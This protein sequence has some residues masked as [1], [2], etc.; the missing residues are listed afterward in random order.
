MHFCYVDFETRSKLDLRKVGARN[1]AV[2]ES[3]EVISIAYALDDAPVVHA[4]WIKKWPQNRTYVAHNAEFEEAIFKR[5]WNFAP[6]FLDTMAL[7]AQMSLPLSLKELAAFFGYAK[8]DTRAVAKLSKP[9]RKSKANPDGELFWERDDV[10]DDYQE[11]DEYNKTD[12][13]VMRACLKKMLPLTEK[14]R[15]I[16]Q[17]TATMNERGVRV[18]TPALA[19]AKPLLAIETNAL[20]AKFVASTGC[21]PRSPVKLAKYFGLPDAK[22]QTI[23]RVLTTAIQPS[24]RSLLE[25]RQ[26]LG[27]SSIGKLQALELRTSSDGF[28]RNS[29]VYAGASRTLRWSSRGVQLQN[30][31]RGLGI[32]TDDAFTW[33][34]NGKLTK[35]LELMPDMIRGFLVGPF[36]VGDYSQIE[37][38]TLAWL[39]KDERQVKEWADGHDLYR[40]MAARIYGKPEKDVTD[41]ERFIGKNTV[42]GCGYG[43]GGKV[44]DGRI[45][46]FQ[47]QLA[48]KFGVDVSPALAELAVTTY[49][50]IYSAVVRLW[51]ELEKAFRVA[52]TSKSGRAD[53]YDVGFER[54]AIRGVRYLCVLLPNG[55]SLYYAHPVSLASGELQAFSP[56]RDNGRGPGPDK[57]YGG[58][59]VEN[60]VQ[61]LARDIMAEAMLRMDEKGFPLVLTVHD[62][63]ATQDDG[64]VG[65][66]TSLMR[67]QPEW[68]PGLPL[69]VE[70]FQCARYRK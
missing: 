52:L 10:P 58:K 59:I 5:F 4:R 49:R 64:R 44:R 42:L 60:I 66:F 53:A 54:R 41:F 8:G 40:R 2:H 68:A 16:W 47:S 32:I 15:R 9:R 24:M 63:I 45:S 28:L 43:M 34:H 29:L 65:E 67:Q 55:G 69:D 39:A 22:A 13:E 33:L 48:D 3:T 61:R 23:K 50:E 38:R 25:L 6:P 17:L 62:E 19:I 30:L 7:A 36:I 46:K 18:D 56:R 35:L 12:V 11:L 26:T 20:T 27:K 31:P 37:A 70:V 14:E 51:Y 57:L 21:S 1:Y